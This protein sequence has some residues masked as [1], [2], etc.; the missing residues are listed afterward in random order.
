MFREKL[1]RLDIFK[2]YLSKWRRK[3]KARSRKKH[4]G[5]AM[6]DM[7]NADNYEG[8]LELSVM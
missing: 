3:H 2:S 7:P 6:G 4:I 1:W 5:R 8:Y